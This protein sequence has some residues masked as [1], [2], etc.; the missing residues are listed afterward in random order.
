MNAPDSSKNG[1]IQNNLQEAHTGDSAP[2]SSDNDTPQNNQQEA[3]AGDS[4]Q[5]VIQQPQQNSMTSDSYSNPIDMYF[6][7]RINEATVEAERR[8]IQ[9]TY[10]G[11][12]KTEFENIIQWLSLRYI[13]E[14]DKDLLLTLMSQVDALV[15]TMRT[16]AGINMGNAYLDAPNNP[17]REMGNGRRSWL[18]QLEA[19]AY[20]DICVYL[21]DND[22]QFINRDYSEMHFE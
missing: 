21:I 2:N 3:H 10:R 6:L 14:E 12:W 17:D 15:T 9:D 11:V 1:I 5:A 22:Y 8:E 16:L 4:V 7:P 20:R 18:N 19:E 13:Y